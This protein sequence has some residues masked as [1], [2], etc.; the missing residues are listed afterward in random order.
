[1]ICFLAA[2]RHPFPWLNSS[3]KAL[4]IVWARFLPIKKNVNASL[5]C[6]EPWAK[7]HQTPFGWVR[8]PFANQTLSV[9]ISTF[10]MAAMFRCLHYIGHVLY[11][12]RW[13]PNCVWGVSSCLP[14]RIFQDYTVSESLQHVL[15]VGRRSTW[16]TT[17]SSRFTDSTLTLMSSRFKALS[18]S[19][20]GTIRRLSHPHSAFL[21]HMP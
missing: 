9:N 14:E 18:Q 17:Y 7:P 4:F 12:Y 16:T 21:Q 10:H 6:T 15:S 1:M 19:F 13:S 3:T 8:G 2:S 5:T 20:T 11:V